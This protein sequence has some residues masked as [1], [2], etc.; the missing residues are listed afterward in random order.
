MDRAGQLVETARSYFCEHADPAQALRYARYF[1]EG[2]DAYGMNQEQMHALRDRL[3]DEYSDLG[4]D[5]MF[6]AGDRLFASG[7]YEEGGLAILLAASF[8][9]PLN[10]AALDRVGLWL[11][12]GVRNWA[13]CDVICG[14]LLAPALQK[15]EV[16]LSLL[17]GWR[18]AP[19]KWKRR[20]VPVAMLGLLKK[21]TGHGELTEFVRPLMSDP[22][23]EVHQGMGWFLR[24]AWKMD[25]VPIEAFLLEWK[26]T[27]PRLI[28]QYA[29]E[30][31]TP[32]QKTRFKRKTTPQRD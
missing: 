28:F 22:V 21:G 14:E 31:M 3:L 5:G 20:A 7:K 18:Q 13:H 8:L 10:A 26:D 24:E 23:R 27:A 1:R 30:K 25:P 15:G 6:E 17:A 4:R 12:N 2:Y 16:E 11:E 19:A 29:T 32:E 9:K